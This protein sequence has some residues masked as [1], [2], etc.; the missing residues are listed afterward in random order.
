MSYNKPLN[1]DSIIQCGIHWCRDP[2]HNQKGM[3][4]KTSQITAM[5]LLLALSGVGTGRAQET[6][7]KKPEALILPRITAE[8]GENF[9][10]RNAPECSLSSIP[11]A[12]LPKEF[13]GQISGFINWPKNYEPPKPSPYTASDKER[14]VADG[15]FYTKVPS[16]MGEGGG[17]RSIGKFQ[18]DKNLNPLDGIWDGKKDGA[19]HTILGKLTMFD[20]E[21]VSE[22]K[23]PLKF[24]ITKDSYVYLEGEGTVKDLKTGTTRKLE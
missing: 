15:M 2:N 21:F 16:S 23:A 6:G 11:L 13:L 4:M 9:D 10:K 18:L 3:K 8:A 7:S 22:E 5:V 14:I 1:T 12:D 24:K 19:I 20:Y 17:F